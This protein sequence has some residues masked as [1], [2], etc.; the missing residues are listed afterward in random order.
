M[1]WSRLT[2]VDNYVEGTTLERDRKERIRRALIEAD[3]GSDEDL[4]AAAEFW[5]RSIEEWRREKK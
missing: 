5:D 3:T 4:K 2:G 1:K